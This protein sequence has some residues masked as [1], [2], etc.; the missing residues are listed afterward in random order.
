MTTF[1]I[2]L[3]QSEFAERLETTLK[4]HASVPHIQ[5]L[6]NASEFPSELHRE[7]GQFGVFGLGIS[8][9][10]GG[11]DGTAIEQVLALRALGMHAN[12]MGV[13]TTVQYLLTAVL[14]DYGTREQK[15]RWLAPLARGSVKGSFCLT[16]SGS[17]TDILASMETVATKTKAGWRL[18]GR[19]RWV[20]GAIGCDLLIVVAR[21]SSHRTRGMT[22]FIVPRELPGI[23]VRRIDTFAIRS[24]DACEVDF[25]DVELPADAVVGEVGEAFAQV[26]GNLNTERISAAAVATGIGMGALQQA[27][28][29]ASERQA[30]G[31]PV[32]QFQALQHR[33]V[34]SSV[35]LECA[36]LMVLRAASDYRD[37][38][39]VDVGSSMAKLAAS[40]AL[41]VIVQTGMETMGANGFE[42][43]HPMQRYYRDS[44]LYA[45][46]PL[47]DDMNI[48][49][50]GERWLGLPRSF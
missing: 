21:T 12:S 16:E 48:N 29:Y 49:L 40:S 33:L 5:A 45:I 28:A 50:I 4:L 18:K 47:A 31:R 15:E 17:G 22:M 36:W 41:K 10:D 32:G 14:R 46:A 26:I 9:K 8:A 27:V 2:A 11:F 30:F 42:N 6:D 1:R 34:R 23:E 19:K 7:L 20:S 3:E 25:H 24:Y 13:F 43:A 35:E 44:R 39:P 38:H 37:G